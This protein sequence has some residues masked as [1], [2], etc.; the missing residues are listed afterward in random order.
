MK[1]RICF[2]MLL[3]MLACFFSSCGKEEKVL[4]VYVVQSEAL[5]KTAVEA[6]VKE[7][8]NAG[9]KVEYFDS[10]DEMNERL[11]TELMSG[12]GPDVLLFNS[13]YSTEDPYKLSV[14][15]S[16]LALD[17]QVVG[18]SDEAYY[19]R[20]MEAGQINGHQYFLPLSWNIVQAYSSQETIAEKGY[21]GNLFTALMTE[22]AELNKDDSRGASNL[23]LN[24]ADVLNYF[25]EIGGNELIDFK[26]GEVIV[27]QDAFKKTAGFVKIIYDNIEKLKTIGTKYR[28]DFAA[29][30]SHFTY[31]L[32]DYSFMN[33]LRYYQSVYPGFVGKEMYFAPFT[34]W[35]SQMITAQII[36]YGA[37][38]ANTGN[39]EGAWKLLKY[40]LDEQTRVDF[41]KYETQSVYYAPVNVEKYTE[42]VSE[43]GRVKGPGPKNMVDPLVEK[44]EQI[45]L[46]IPKKVGK[47]VLPNKALGGL[48]QECME[49]YLLER[50]SFEICYE[51]LIQRLKLYLN[52]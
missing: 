16:L 2:L 38:N 32:E 35:D 9:L 34:Q 50:D 6:Y 44:N 37:V 14:S 33:N 3:Y 15:N 18:L 30:I 11:K 43:L 5:Y 7:Y 31:L 29:A 46:D 26:T 4:S 17:E 19:K 42:C 12:K 13:F 47:A 8:P 10:Y 48:I 41:S 22:A 24:R 36:Q 21:D 45:L 25:C 28:N 39:E 27:Q 40:I 1:K 20:I 52:E 23:S 49:P 51:N